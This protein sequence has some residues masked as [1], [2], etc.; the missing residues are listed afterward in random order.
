[1]TKRPE[2]DIGGDVRTGGQIVVI[3]YLK[4]LCRKLQGVLE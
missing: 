3:K 4:A 1:M 2:C